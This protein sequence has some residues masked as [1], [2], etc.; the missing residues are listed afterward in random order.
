M[1]TQIQCEI[2]QRLQS[3]YAHEADHLNALIDEY[4]NAPSADECCK[5]IANLSFYSGLNCLLPKRMLGDF[6]DLLSPMLSMGAQVKKSHPDCHLS[7]VYA[8][9]IFEVF[10]ALL[11][12]YDWL[13]TDI[14]EM[15]KLR[16][17]YSGVLG[18]QDLM[19]ADQFFAVRYPKRAELNVDVPSRLDSRHRGLHRNAVLLAYPSSLFTMFLEHVGEGVMLYEDPNNDQ[20]SFAIIAS[21]TT[22]RD[23]LEW[24]LDYAK[25]H[26]FID[27][28]WLIMQTLNNVDDH[29]SEVII[30]FC[31]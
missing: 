21:D 8:T 28:A 12:E 6:S 2:F 14:C 9:N 1:Y 30:T 19:Y 4:F 10:V 31:D 5:L 24:Q 20:N 25:R 11:S 23:W 17:P 16:A 27:N 13:F 18:T 3:N 26:Q 15:N 22:P 7:D 29:V